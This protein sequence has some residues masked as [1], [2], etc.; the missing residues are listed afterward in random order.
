MGNEI[1]DER[2]NGQKH[3]WSSR[4]LSRPVVMYG[5]EDLSA[6]LGIQKQRAG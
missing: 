3:Y 5:R 2:L 4:G 1:D 6:K